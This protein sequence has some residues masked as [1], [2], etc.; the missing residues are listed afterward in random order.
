MPYPIANAGDT[1]LEDLWG[2]STDFVSRST[3]ISID[4]MSSN[5]QTRQVAL[6]ELESQ[7]DITKEIL[8]KTPNDGSA[9]LIQASIYVA[10]ED[11]LSANEAAQ[12]AL[13]A[14]PGKEGIIAFE[15]M[16]NIASNEHTH[17]LG[18]EGMLSYDLL[19]VDRQIVDFSL[20]FIADFSPNKEWDNADI[21]LAHVYL[22]AKLDL[23][24]AAVK[25]AGDGSLFTQYYT[26]LRSFLDIYSK[27]LDNSNRNTDYFLLQ[28][29]YYD[30]SYNEANGNHEQTLSAANEYRNI[31]TQ[32]I[33]KD[34]YGSSIYGMLITMKLDIAQMLGDYDKIKVEVTSYYKENYGTVTFPQPFR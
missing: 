20:P 24:A 17:K 27:F 2:Q 23:L 7:L 14:L 1:S 16:H 29:I 12:A 9:L 8:A 26:D 19:S 13:K 3:Q 22:D 33:E 28:T 34:G 10:L 25:D 30:A 5:P 4:A 18:S 6:A 15:I 31:E 21:N 32:M 11:Y